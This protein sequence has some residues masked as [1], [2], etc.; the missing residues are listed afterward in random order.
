[1]SLITKLTEQEKKIVAES[2]WKD[3]KMQEYLI[4]KYDYY[5]TSDGIIIEIQKANSLSINKTIWYDDELP[6]DLVPKLCFGNFEVENR[7]NCNRYDC[8]NREF[9]KHTKFYFCNG[10]GTISFIDYDRFNTGNIDYIKRE[11]TKEEMEEILSIYKEQKDNYIERLRKY[12]KRYNNKISVQG[13]W[14]NR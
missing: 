14:A 4:K 13:Y 5:K 7:H 12:Y 2:E 10:G 11:I 6:N 8:Y 9:H 1:M 3:K